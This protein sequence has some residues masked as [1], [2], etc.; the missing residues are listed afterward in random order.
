MDASQ[1]H[2]FSLFRNVDK[3]I[4]KTPHADAMS[5]AVNNLILKRIFLDRSESFFNRTEEILAQLR[6]NRFVLL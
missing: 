6:T 5:I 4:W 2:D 1:H 3:A